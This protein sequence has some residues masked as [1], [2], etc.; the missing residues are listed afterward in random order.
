MF[1][2]RDAVKASRIDD[3][4]SGL[5]IFVV[6]GVGCDIIWETVSFKILK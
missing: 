3:F 1:I 6:G 2:C 5:S 4:R